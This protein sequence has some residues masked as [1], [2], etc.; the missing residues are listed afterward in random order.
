MTPKAA[1]HDAGETLM[2]SNLNKP[3]SHCNE[4]N[5][6]PTPL[7]VFHESVINRSLLCDCQLQG[8]NEFVHESLT[9]HVFCNQYGIC[10]SAIKDL[11]WG[12]TG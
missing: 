7:P 6:V 5:N 8:G 4:H 3:Y 11:S 10:P 12:C 9:Q 1:I 2:L